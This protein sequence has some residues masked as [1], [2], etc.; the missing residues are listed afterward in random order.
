MIH[1]KTQQEIAAMR[2]GGQ[3]LADI[4]HELSITVRPGMTTKD[5]DVI[6]EDLMFKKKVKPSF[7]GYHDYP[8]VICTSINEEI[9]HGIPTSRVIQDGDII[10]IDCGVVHKGFHTDSA[11]CIMI[12]HVKPDVRKFVLTVQKSFE[13]GLAAVRPGARTGDIGFAVQHHIESN[14]YSIVRDFI[15]HG[16]GK[17]LHEE[18]EI[19]NVGSK[20][21]GVLLVPGMVIAIE[22]IVAMGQRYSRILKDD[23]TAVTKDN[24]L[25]CQVEHTIAILESGAEV[26]TMYNNT[27]NNIY[28]Q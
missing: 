15:G 14:G 19:H 23:W 21:K 28:P 11:T 10:K 22:P 12:G 24:S 20:G 1:I 25:A 18:P 8:A 5:L 9:V 13:R 26:L 4:L 17:S 16:V 3:I 6:A 2:E 27:I 7:K